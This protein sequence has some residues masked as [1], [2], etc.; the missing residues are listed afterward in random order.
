[1]FL[2]CSK[3][4]KGAGCLAPWF[5]EVLIF[6]VTCFPLGTSGDTTGGML[7]RLSSAVSR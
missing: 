7:A 1:M 2:F 3:G 5:S 4:V 6:A